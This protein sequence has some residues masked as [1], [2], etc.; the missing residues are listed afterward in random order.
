MSK[1]AIQRNQEIVEGFNEGSS[2]T[3]RLATFDWN[4]TRGIGIFEF[5]LTRSTSY[6]YRP[7]LVR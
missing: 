5:A 4:R 7:T 2:L 3:D 6:S 1:R